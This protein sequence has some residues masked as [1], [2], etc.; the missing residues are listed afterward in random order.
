MWRKVA[1]PTSALLGEVVTLVR[2]VKGHLKVPDCTVA[3]WF[4]DNVMSSKVP[5][6]DV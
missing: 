1:Q 4:N 3:A 6:D 5:M 2:H